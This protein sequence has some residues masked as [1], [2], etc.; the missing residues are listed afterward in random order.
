M[1]VENEHAHTAR[2]REWDEL[3]K[4]R[5]RDTPPCVKQTAGGKL[6]S[7]TVLS[8]QIFTK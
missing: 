4:Q 5:G 1:N 6:V 3:R 7:N 8:E 2:E